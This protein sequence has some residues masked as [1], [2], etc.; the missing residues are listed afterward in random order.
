MRFFIFFHFVFFFC[1]E[2]V[3]TLKRPLIS[4]PNPELQ[5]RK[6][7]DPELQITKMSDRKKAIGDPQLWEI[8]L[9]IGEMKQG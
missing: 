9:G 3:K 2:N 8:S 6:I 5:I 7:S 4:L 1:N